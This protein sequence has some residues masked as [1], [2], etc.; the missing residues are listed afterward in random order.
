[1]ADLF[2]YLGPLTRAVSFGLSSPDRHASAAASEL[3]LALLRAHG[4]RFLDAAAP[5][6]VDVDNA[7]VR[8]ILAG[9]SRGE[10]ADHFMPLTWNR[11]APERKAGTRLHAFS[12]DAVIARA[13]APSLG[14]GRHLEQWL[15]TF[16]L[17]TISNSPADCI[18]ACTTLATSH[19]P[20]AMQLFNSAFLSCWAQVSEKGRSQITSSFRDLL[21]AAGPYEP[22]ARE[23]LNLLVFMH[24]IE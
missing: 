6:L 1:V 4:Q 21:L 2:T 24:K 22:V 10:Y 19:Y 14:S 16:V 9:I 3:L 5:L 12:E 18:R 7:E 13:M 11:S 15:R 8:E 23:V 20:L 17:A